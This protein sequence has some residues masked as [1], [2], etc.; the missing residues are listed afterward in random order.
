MMMRNTFVLMTIL[1]VLAGCSLSLPKP[2]DPL[3]GLEVTSHMPTQPVD[4]RPYQN[5]KIGLILSENTRNSIQW[6]KKEIDRINRN[7][8]GVSWASNS[9]EDTVQS[10]DHSGLAVSV[11]RVL[12]EKFKNAT[13]VPD[14]HAAINEGINTVVVIDIQAKGDMTCP[15]SIT[16]CYADTESQHSL[17]FVDTQT[18]NPIAVVRG[19]ASITYCNVPK[20]DYQ[21]AY[22]KCIQD[23]R[24]KSLDVLRTKLATLLPDST[25]AHET[26]QQ[27]PSATPAQVEG[28]EENTNTINNGSSAEMY[29]LGLRMEQ[30]GNLTLAGVV[31]QAIVRRFPDSP[32]ATKALERQ[33]T[34][35]SH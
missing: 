23:G 26:A 28:Y 31:Y 12:K 1:A 20:V 8:A 24:I 32:F 16:D 4:L 5:Q 33:E 21:F 35:I 11:E 17:I 10:N 3:H 6:K 14:I 30:S 27:R 7:F 15:S 9:D 19:K 22:A 34:M 18:R 13:L 29:S 2:I 25:E